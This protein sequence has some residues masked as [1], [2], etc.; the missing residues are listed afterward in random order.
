MKKTLSVA[1]LAAAMFVCGSAANA[2][3]TVKFWYHFDNADN[4]MSDLVQKF[5]AKNPGIKIDAENIP[6][7]SYYDNLYTSIIAGS[8]PDAAMVKM[9]AQPRLV[10][11][12]ALEPLDDRI[13]AWDGASDIQENLFDLTKGPDGKQYYLPVQY[14]VLYLYYRADM[15]KELGLEPP[16]TCDD[17]RNAAIK[18]TRDTNNDGRKDVYGFGFR[19][20][21]GGHDHWGSLVLSR[22]GV[23]FDKGGLTSD[24]GVAGTQFVVDLFQ[25][26]KV[27]PPSAPN[28]GFKEVTGAFKAGTTAMT[29][30]H[31]GSANDM[32]AALGD[33]VSATTVP[34]CGGGRWTSFGDES[35]A[36]FSSAKNKDAAWKWIAFLSSE[37]NNKEFNEST[38]QLPVTK[39]DSANWTLHPK[40][41]VDATIAS[42]PFAHMLPNR[43]ETSDFVNTEWPVN[44][45]RALTGEITA[46]KMNEK[47]D[48]L[49]NK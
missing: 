11:M 2:E 4:P 41:F 29:I 21:K 8:A 10:E 31:I 22:E 23:S 38:G 32:V 13:A 3:D 36:V 20:G 46:K 30:H 35:T 28:D 34:E 7:N 9:H 40:R 26:D 49:F 44:M 14:V 39:S 6:W 17:F 24:A 25:K 12:G 27:F 16:K 33:K 47:I 45:Q 5:E 15:F 19:G 42:L 18:L 1:A 48:A 37:G 43:P